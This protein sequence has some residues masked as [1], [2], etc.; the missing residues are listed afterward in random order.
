[1]TGDA[2]HPS[3]HRPRNANA[4]P[5]VLF[6]TFG[7]RVNQYETDA[8]KAQLAENCIV[9]GTS[10]PADVIIINGCTVTALAASKTR[11][12]I[13]Q[14]RRQ[15]PEAV[16]VLIGCL[17]EAAKQRWAEAGD[18]DLMAGNGW[19]RSVQAV[20][21]QALSGQRGSLAVAPSVPIDREVI[22]PSFDG[23]GNRVRG[24]LKVQDGCSGSCTYCQ[25]RLVRGPAHSKSVKAVVAEAK[26][27]I[28][29]GVPE[30]VLSGINLSE[31]APSD[32]D[33]A[34]LILQLD[35]IPE[36]KR[37]RLGSINPEGVTDRLLDAVS[38]ADSACPHLHISV[39]SGDDGILHRMNRRY[40]TSEIV[41]WT[42]AARTKVRGIT[43]GTD[44]IVGFPGE[45]EEAFINTCTLIERIGFV[46]LHLFRYSRREGTPAIHLNGHVDGPTQHRRASELENR[47]RKTLE[48][49]LLERIDEDRTLLVERQLNGR[50]QGYSEDYIH[51]RLDDALPLQPGDT[52]PVRTTSSTG[53]GWT[54]AVC[55]SF[56]EQQER[57]GQGQGDHE[58]T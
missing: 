58:R 10:E 35:R 30:L 38:T 15:H 51:L 18:P 46:N 54:A 42:D 20:V 39:Q 23:L 27:M 6:R 37:I 1:M 44:V 21:R 19:K 2:I 32:G 13:R 49:W 31:Y 52:V 48:R 47:W 3:A 8:M 28:A 40:T 25:T 43:F 14:A 53:E 26:A 11:K 33:L 50:W 12:A 55:S 57:Q 36:L 34:D 29:A 16:V 45:S 4:R 17:A 9:D 5:V 56:R 24:F 22:P 7:C 41:Q